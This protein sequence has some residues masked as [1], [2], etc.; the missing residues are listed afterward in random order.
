MKVCKTCLVEKE[1]SAFTAK[2]GVCKVCRSAVQAQVSQ[3]QRR[4]RYAEERDIFLNTVVRS[5]PRLFLTPR[6]YQRLAANPK[7]KFIH[8][9]DFPS[10]LREWYERVYARDL[11]KGLIK[12]IVEMEFSKGA[13]IQIYTRFLI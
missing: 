3:E 4:A 1:D 5:S 7:C 8:L 12:D 6:E 13:G 9:K 2:R 11:K 10:P